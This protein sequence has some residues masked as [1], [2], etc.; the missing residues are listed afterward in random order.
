MI[1]IAD[2]GSTTCDWVLVNED[3]QVLVEENTQGINPVMFDSTEINRRLVQAQE[4]IAQA[5]NVRKLYFYSAGCGTKKNQNLMKQNLQELY[6]NAHIEVYSDL[7]AAVRSTALEPSIVCILGTGS[8]SCF[9]DGENIIQGYDSLGFSIMDEASGNYLGKQLLRDY[10][11]KKMPNSISEKFE[12]EF[13][14]AADTVLLHLYKKAMP[15]QYM[16]SFAKFIFDS[17]HFETEYIQKLLR[18]AFEEFTTYQI[19]FW[20]QHQEV[21][22]HFVGSIAFYSKKILT[23]ILEVE[24]IEVGNFVAKPI[25]GLVDFHLT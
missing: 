22:I 16:A 2:S 17:S 19:K 24:K 8:N 4:I 15:A 11:Y 9:F 5:S 12:N 23:D 10:F 18:N 20:S 1:V 13:E 6:P 14:L 3:K 21:P 25:K 7:V